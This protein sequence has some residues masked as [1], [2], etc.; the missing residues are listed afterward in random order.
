MKPKSNSLTLI[1]LLMIIV[2]FQGSSDLY[3]AS[4]PFMQHYFT[5][6][7]VNIQF[8][9]TLFLLA[10]G[11]GQFF[12]VYFSE[13]FSRK[14]ILIVSLSIFIIASLLAVASRTLY[15]LYIARIFQGFAVSALNLNI[16]AM[17][18]EIL[19]D[20]KI[21]IFFTYFALFWGAGGTI[22]PWVG[23]RIQHSFGWRYN[24]LLLA[25]YGGLALFL[26]LWNVPKKT[27]NQKSGDIVKRLVSD[28]RVVL[29][30]V[31]FISGILAQGCTLSLFL[32]FN[33]FM[34]FYIQ[35]TL[36]YSVVFFG[37]MSFFVGL[38]FILGC[39][40]FRIA[41][42]K[43]NS[44]KLCLLS[45]IVALGMSILLLVTYLIGFEGAAIIELFVCII[46]FLSGFMAS[47]NIG[48]TMSYFK[49]R[50]TVS[51]CSHTALHFCMAA[52]LILFLSYFQSFGLQA[53]IIFYCVAILTFIGLNQ[54]CFRRIPS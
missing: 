47:E 33:Y 50:A 8:T 5:T 17:P 16:K 52:V 13:R 11:I 19:S 34:S 28:F 54:F 32:A 25:V 48:I 42:K 2:L 53:F 49:N 15:M 41:S 20:E 4:M 24:F 46:I 40:A 38:S 18:L 30:D 29:S 7:I 23:S 1:T 21:K 31:G 36:G 45:S 27:G 44:N 9:I 12:W 6:G 10:Y 37:Y 22:A 14:Q 35:K 43:I 51:S 3:S 26:V 39:L